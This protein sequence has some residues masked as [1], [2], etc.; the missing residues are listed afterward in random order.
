MSQIKFTH[1][2]IIM[3]YNTIVDLKQ[4]RV[5]CGNKEHFDKRVESIINKID[6]YLAD[7][8]G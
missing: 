1:P 8:L 4:S 6:Q 2:E 3:I 7:K 5:Y